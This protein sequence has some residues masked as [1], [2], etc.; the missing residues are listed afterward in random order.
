MP[1][2]E[3]YA[4]STSAKRVL[5]GAGTPAEEAV[6]WLRDALG[7][8]APRDPVTRRLGVRRHRLDLLADLC[9]RDT[10]LLVA[11]WLGSEAVPAIQSKRDYA[12]DIRMWAGVARELGGYERF[13]LG[14]ISSEMIETWTKIQKA[15]NVKPRTINRRLSVLTSF[16]KYAAWK[17]KSTDIVSPVSRYDRPHVD[18]NDESSATPILEKP[19]FEAVMRACETSQQAVTVAL[20]YTLAGRVTECC[21]AK[22][23]SLITVNGKKR[24]DITR[25]RSKERGWPIPDD[26]MDLISVT[27]KGRPEDDPLLVDDNG[28]AMDRH[29]VDRMLTR[30][31]KRAGVLPGREL[32][33]HV[34]RAT[35][36]THMADEGVDLQ[37]IRDYADHASILTTER[38]VRMRELM[39]RRAKHAENAVDAYRHL[40]GKFIDPTSDT[41]GSAVD[42]VA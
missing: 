12:D 16:T 32:T 4:P 28:R 15:R 20:I 2:Q 11:S 27:T 37:D 10:F 24:L 8:V 26:L 30:I 29:A 7:T 41:P 38:Y 13:F 14:C 5:V 35:R 19:E 17:L 23:S 21:K 3:V 34:L 31:G 42:A 1:E 36:L 6:D 18:P 39:K 9:E 22:V 40:I 25:K 33:P